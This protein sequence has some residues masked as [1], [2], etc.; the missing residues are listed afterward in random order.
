MRDG[1]YNPASLSI[2]LWCW[3]CRSESVLQWLIRANRHSWSAARGM[4]LLD[5]CFS[6]KKRNPKPNCLL[7]EGPC[8]LNEPY[9][10][11]AAPL[12]T[13]LTMLMKNIMRACPSHVFL[14]S[15]S[16]AWTVLAPL[17]CWQPPLRGNVFVLTPVPRDHNRTRTWKNSSTYIRC[18]KKNSYNLLFS[19]LS[20][21][22][23]FC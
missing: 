23:Y 12:A 3:W 13:D 15:I 16:S 4:L 18:F 14:E 2:R 8:A 17:P 10:I 11:P 9:H 20:P 6:R 7:Q 5:C 19:S 1:F 21:L 22:V